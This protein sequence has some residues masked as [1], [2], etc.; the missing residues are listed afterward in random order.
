[1]GGAVAK[2]VLGGFDAETPMAVGRSRSRG[3]DYCSGTGG[4]GISAKKGGLVGLEG[5]N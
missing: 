1:M 3:D 4:N 2:K 5:V